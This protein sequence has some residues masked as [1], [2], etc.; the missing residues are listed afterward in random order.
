MR[1]ISTLVLAALLFASKPA[2]AIERQQAQNWCWAA[3]INDAISSTGGYRSQAA[4]VADLTGWPQDRPAYIEEVVALYTL[5]GFKSWR[6]GRPG[7]YQ[8]LYATL[9]NGWWIT[10]FI[11]QGS[12]GVGHF[13]NVKT[14]DP[15]SGY[16]WYADP[17]TGR[18]GWID[19]GA[20]YS[21]WQDA[22]I[23]GR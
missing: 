7:T 22:V 12:S 1:T 16:L 2:E 8:E 21:M 13:I 3:V 6:T 15:Q 5:Y 4:I 10:A 19:P 18:E 23:V 20:L 17:W 11:R 14:F 9:A